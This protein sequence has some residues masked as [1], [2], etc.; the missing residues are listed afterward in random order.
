MTRS[1]STGRISGRLVFEDGGR[2]LHNMDLELCVRPLWGPARPLAQG[3]TDRDGAFILTVE[4]PIPRRLELRLLETQHWYDD[5][6]RVQV[7]HRPVY[8]VRRRIPAG[9]TEWG[10]LTI[11]YW[12][13]DPDSPLVRVYVAD[14]KNPPEQY[15]PGR[16]PQHFACIGNVF[17][18]LLATVRWHQLLNRINPNWPSV[19]S[20]QA[21]FPPNLTRRMEAERPGST[22]SDTFFGQR[23]LNGFNPCLLS[24]DRRNPERYR[25]WCNWD[26]YEQDG[27]HDLPNVDLRFEV[28]EEALWPVEITL[29]FR[30]QGGKAPYS[31]LAPP[32]TYTPADG[33]RWEQA[34]R[35]CRMV[36]GVTGELDVHLGR[37][38]LNTEQYAVAA[39]RN[40]RRNPLKNL[41]FP[42][43]REITR[44][45]ID[46]G[47][48]IFGEAGVMS[49]GSALTARSARLRVHDR[50]ASLDWKGWRPRQ[51]ICE[52]HHYAKAAN[53]FWQ[54]LTE[55][56]DHFFAENEAEI[57]AHWYE[58]HRFSHDLVAHSLPYQPPSEDPDDLWTD[59]GEFGDRTTPRVVIDG[60][61]RAL[62]PVTRSDEPEAG[63]LE[64]LQ[65]LARY[66]IFHASLLHAWSNARQYQ[67]GGDLFFSSLGMRNG[68]MG[69]ED[70]LSIGPLPRG[71]AYQLFLARYLSGVRY[72]MIM[73]NEDRD[74]HP[75]LPQ[76]LRRHE[77]EFLR[78]EVDIYDVQ[79]R[80]N[81]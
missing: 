13:Y 10:T 51:P 28:R 36:F 35:V 20:A 46:G 54:V 78:Y 31:P 12:K 79:A 5:Q 67:E 14:I 81:I 23:V 41:L 11:P 52:G 72:G 74:I 60:R 68:S 1:E 70:D 71:A 65:E 50:V 75:I 9:K 25:Y 17:Y 21:A 37:G 18:G 44:V 62:R 4:A 33:A 3:T 2:P 43:L 22:R 47:K 32:T 56:V 73:T 66:L 76:L 61:P 49:Q 63:E 34:K 55:Y 8:R 15:T 48:L 26:A 38:H 29:Q 7:E 30:K 16:W 39:R 69:P 40:L 77:E 19:H 57:H 80:T 27:I 24:R 64:L 59:L 53:L 58:V 6:G 42:H 45:N